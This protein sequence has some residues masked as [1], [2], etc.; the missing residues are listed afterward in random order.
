MDY[1]V[2]ARKFRPQ[3]FD[4]IV[5]QETVTVTLK[6][7]IKQGRIP[8]SFLFSG[9]RGVGKTSTARILAKALNCKEGPTEKPCGKCLAC[10]EIERGNSMD[11]IEIDGASNRR[12]EEIRDLR[13]NVKFKPTS[14][15]FKIYIIDEV[16]MLTLEAF[17]AL[18]K[19][20]EEPPPHV[21][22][23]FATTESHKVPLTILSRCQRFQ[24]KRIPVP[25]VVK[26][27]E[28][29]AKKEKLK[30]DEKALFLMAK[31]S[32]GALRDAES[33]LDQLAS[34]SG[35]KITEEDVLTLLGASSDEIY[36]DVL[37]AI[38]ERKGADLFALVKKIY[39][40]GGELAQFAAG[41]FE[42]FRHL[43]V[44]KVI[45]E[46]P[47]FIDASEAMVKGLKKKAAD[48]SEGELLL[49]LSML[50]NL[51]YQL[52][53]PVASPKLLVETALLR[54]MNVGR[55]KS[56]EE[57]VGKNKFAP[58]SA[59]TAGS[60]TK[61]L[62]EKKTVPPSQKSNEPVKFKKTAGDENSVSPQ[63]SSRDSTESVDL[64]AVVSVWPQVIE[65]V[66]AKRMS[67]GLYL[68]ASEP[69]EVDDGI[70]T[71]G[72]PAEFKFH[73]ETL[74][75][76][77]NRKLIEEMFCQALGK[78]VR[79]QC[80]MTEKDGIH[81]DLPPETPSTDNSPDIVAQALEIF[82]GARVIRKE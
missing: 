31:A 61:P 47:G 33:L 16:H 20:L 75:K 46:T 77:S 1:L 28:S 11:V 82:D 58:A 53:R 8:Q 49:A 56:V 27:L 5:G 7:A 72:F 54:L 22:F 35:G 52:R 42:V 39:E 12:I 65:S 26:K 10:K 64:N 44:L 55:L 38:R 18:L 66:K 62:P 43:L 57:L 74:E 67:L 78:K 4:E 73:K 13:E 63:H 60:I 76:E 45:R 40:E 6:N 37:T 2:Y 25:E 17:N 9:P 71:L 15:N 30:C 79:V 59:S 51:Q 81:Q 24:F 48:F 21:K 68:A 36:L 23:I 69:M 32:E 14:G 19:T 29:I 34:F 80:V 41:L 50:Q 3:T 70:I